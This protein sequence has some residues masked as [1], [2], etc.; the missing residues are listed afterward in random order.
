MNCRFTK[1]IFPI[2]CHPYCH[3]K[4]DIQAWNEGC[5]YGIDFTGSL[6]SIIFYQ[7]RFK[8][9]ID[10]YQKESKSGRELPFAG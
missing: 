7:H 6:S 1:G 3:K 5:A 4:T 10:Q 8:I 9:A 2:I